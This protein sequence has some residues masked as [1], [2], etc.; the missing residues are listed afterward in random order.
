R[1]HTHKL[2]ARAY[3]KNV[4]GRKVC[5]QAER[6]S[7]YY[8]VLRRRVERGPDKL[9][10]RRVGRIRY[11]T[12]NEDDGRN[13][14]QRLRQMHGAGD[15][16]TSNPAGWR[17]RAHRLE[18]RREQIADFLLCF[19]IAYNDEIPFLAVARTRCTSSGVDHTLD[20]VLR[21]RIGLQV[22]RR[23]AGFHRFD[24]I[25]GRL[26]FD[27]AS[28]IFVTHQQLLMSYASHGSQVD[29]PDEP[30]ESPRCHLTGEGTYMVS[31]GDSTPA[32]SKG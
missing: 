13:L 4:N 5:A 31:G 9:L 10:H 8:Q 25:H 24:D 21:H 28:L 22:A 1:G 26:L 3:Q 11:R 15:H 7:R 29:R 20:Q 27:S 32:R 14:I 19:R 12:A 17:S 23:T 18:S 6:A 30:N 16:S 2:A